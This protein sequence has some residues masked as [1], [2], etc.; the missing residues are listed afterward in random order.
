MTTVRPRLRGPLV[1]CV[2]AILAGCT[3][4]SGLTG[5]STYAC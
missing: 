5:I 3:S 4:L 1:I 2:M